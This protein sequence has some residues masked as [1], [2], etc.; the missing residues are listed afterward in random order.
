[1]SVPSWSVCLHVHLFICLSIDIYIIQ[2]VYVP[3]FIFIYLFSFSPVCLYL[4][5]SI[6]STNNDHH[7]GISRYAVLIRFTFIRLL[8]SSPHHPD[9]PGLEVNVLYLVVCASAGVASLI[10]CTGVIGTHWVTR[11]RSLPPY[12]QPMTSLQSIFTN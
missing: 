1:M 4:L 9:L 3:V 2:C 11:A 10:V 12:L 6:S 5:L 8:I 7:Q